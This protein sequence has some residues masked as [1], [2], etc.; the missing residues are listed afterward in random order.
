MTEVRMIFS[1]MG[2]RHGWKKTVSVAAESEHSRGCLVAVLRDAE[3]LNSLSR[4]VLAEAAR[5]CSWESALCLLNSESAVAQT[6]R[7]AGLTCHTAVQAAA[8]AKR[9]WL[10]MLYTPVITTLIPTPVEHTRNSHHTPCAGNRESTTAADGMVDHSKQREGSDRSPTRMDS[11]D[12]CGSS[13]AACGLL[14][15][16]PI[17]HDRVMSDGSQTHVSGRHHHF[18]MNVSWRST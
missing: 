5:H 14:R 4:L 2:T 11:S 9:S 10:G 3:V 16:G 8:P 6:L 1:T 7:E 12:H 15:I 13:P 17:A 18:I